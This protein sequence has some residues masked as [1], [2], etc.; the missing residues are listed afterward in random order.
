M[1]TNK[2]PMEQILE[3]SQPQAVR[4][5]VDRREKLPYLFNQYPGA[6]TVLKTLRTGDYSIAGHEDY[7]AVER[8]SLD[9]F[10]GSITH[11]RKRFFRELDRLAQIPYRCIV[12]ADMWCAVV[13]GLWERQVSIESVSGTIQ[14]ILQD[15][16]IPVYF[17]GDRYMAQEFVYRFLEY[18]WRRMN[19]EVPVSRKWLE[20]AKRRE[21]RPVAGSNQET[22]F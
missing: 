18:R 9:D 11:G 10:L 21:A 22:I 4:I 3:K 1:T 17:L 20:Q 5:A 12:I 8:K 6:T 14:C 2:K 7:I 13:D 16:Q 19:D 15:F